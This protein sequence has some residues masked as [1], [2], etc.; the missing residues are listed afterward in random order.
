MCASKTTSS[1]LASIYDIGIIFVSYK[2][3]SGTMASICDYM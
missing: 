1:T 2:T 3:L